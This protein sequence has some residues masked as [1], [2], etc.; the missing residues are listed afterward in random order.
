VGTIGVISA[1][2]GSILITINHHKTLEE[3]TDVDGTELTTTG[4]FPSWN[5]TEGYFDFDKNIVTDYVPY[6][7]ANAELDL[8]A[9][10]FIT[11]GQITGEIVKISDSAP[12]AQ[13][14]NP[15]YDTD[16][17]V[18]SPYG[19]MYADDITEVIDVIN[20]G[21]YYPMTANMSTGLVSGFTFQNSCE[22]KCLIAGNYNINWGMSL[23]S[24]NNK[25]LEGAVMVNGT[26]VAGAGKGSA[27]TPGAGDEVHVTGSGGITLAVNDVIKLCVENETDT[28]DITVHS[29]SLF[30]SKLPDNQTGVYKVY[31]NGDWATSGTN[32][33]TPSLIVETAG[34]VDG[35]LRG[36]YLNSAYI[37]LLDMENATAEYLNRITIS[38]I[39]VQCSVASP[40]TQLSAK[41]MYCDAQ[42]TGAFPGANPTEIDVI[43]TTTGN[44][45]VT[46]LSTAVATN[47]IVYLQ[48]TADPT[49]YNTSWSVNFKYTRS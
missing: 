21:Q 18:T 29:A 42:G 39:N 38:A 48:M 25:H 8:G 10:D 23:S 17:T 44:F 43:D 31:A 16:A 5:Q 13:E 37:K 40:T 26:A 14:G 47:K 15:W 6:T 36:A 49:D 24:G 1:T 7:G 41:L 3:L 19:G 30:L 27:H 2:Q 45:S 4:Q 12:I 20:S 11:T 28:T 32:L 46:G 9:E 35:N 22:L 34:I 33:I